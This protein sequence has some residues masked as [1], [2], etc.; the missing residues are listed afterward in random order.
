MSDNLKASFLDLLHE[1]EQESISL[2]SGGG[3]GLFL[4]QTLME[5]SQ[6][7]VISREFWPAARSTKDIDLLLNPEIITSPEHM[8][9]LLKVPAQPKGFETKLVVHKSQLRRIQESFRTD[10]IL[11]VGRVIQKKTK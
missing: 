10:F 9:T 5:G 7:T 2:I 8:R 1:C 11:L 3:F 6:Q 4:K